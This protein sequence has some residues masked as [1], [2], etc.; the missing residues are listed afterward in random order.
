M[1]VAHILAIVGGSEN[2]AE[3][4]L[5]E[6]QESMPERVYETAELTISFPVS[7]QE[8]ERISDAVA[9]KSPD[10][11]L[12]FLSGEQLM[13][14]GA[15]FFELA[16]SK[17]WSVPIVALCPSA[18]PDEVIELLRLGASD[19]LTVPSDLKKVILRR[20]SLHGSADR[21][22][23]SVA[24]L[25]AKLGLGHIIGESPAFVAL[26]NQIPPISKY[27]VSLL[28]LGETGTGKEVFARAIH[29]RSSRAANP[30]FRLTAAPSRWNF[31]KMSSSA[32]NPARSRAPIP[33]VAE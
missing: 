6:I 2:R 16:C 20:L 4:T 12:L 13:Q 10:L 9:D 5:K 29:Y 31:S 1:K 11:L 26:I 23:S 28:I 8:A 3:T 30:S 15:N 17:K 33:R 18:K 21:G 22:D 27:D 25:R 19:V 7:D 32:M 24:Q 14:A